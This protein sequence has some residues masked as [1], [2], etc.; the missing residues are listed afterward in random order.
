MALGVS[1]SKE[2]MQAEREVN[3]MTDELLKKNARHYS[4][5]IR[6]SLPHWMKSYRFRRKVMRSVRKQKKN[7][8][9]LKVNFIINCWKL[10]DKLMVLS[11]LWV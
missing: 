7:W 11:F 2:A 4:I 6:N 3:N 5:P 10:T 1:H 9:V 8:H